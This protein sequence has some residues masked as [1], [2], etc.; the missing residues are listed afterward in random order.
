VQLNELATSI[1]VSTEV[2]SQL[3]QTYSIDLA[4]ITPK[5]AESLKTVANPGQLATK[6]TK[7][8]PAKQLG[9]DPELALTQGST[10]TLTAPDAPAIATPIAVPQMSL[11]DVTD[12]FASLTAGASLPIEQAA[13]EGILRGAE[14]AQGEA[15][16]TD[17]FFREIIGNHYKA[18]ISQ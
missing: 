11:S 10:A 3:L 13:R 6:P 7:K 12:Y 2:A 4:N 8:V 5:E 9:G 1:G 17:S 16:I 14:I 15:S 18:R